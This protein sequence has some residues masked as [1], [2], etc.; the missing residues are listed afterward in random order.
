MRHYFRHMGHF[1]NQGAEWRPTGARINESWR[2]INNANAPSNKGGCMPISDICSPGLVT[3]QKGASI[4]FVAA[5]MKRLHVGTVIVVESE[6]HPNKPI[7][8]ITDRDIVLKAVAENLNLSQLHVGD[9]MSQNLAMIEKEK[10]VYDAIKIMRKRGVRRLLV[11]DGDQ[12]L[13]GI[14]S[15]DD[16]LQMLGD[17]MS[18]IGSLFQ[19]QSRNEEKYYPESEKASFYS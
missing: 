10:G 14:L 17:E 18:E 13:C 11:V 19:S 9:I 8:I 16:L 12:R 3:V 1:V 15:S 2:G 6:T 5:L 4:Q 7:G